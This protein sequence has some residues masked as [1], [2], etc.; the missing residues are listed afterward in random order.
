MNTIKVNCIYGDFMFETIVEIL[1]LV[2]ALSVDSFAAGLVYGV[3]KVKVPLLSVLIITFIS[4]MTLIIS[5]FIGNIISGMLPENFTDDVSFL[6]IYTIGV[7]KLLQKPKGDEADKA[8]KAN[9]DG[10]NILS[11]VEALYL[12]AALSIDSIAA[13]IGAGVMAVHAAWTLCVSLLVG[14][15]AIFFGTWLGRIISSRFRSDLQWVSGILMILLAFM[16]RV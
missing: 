3:G 6:I 4:S 10:D 9:K 8:D 11:P 16:R 15:L 5:I 12:G 1:V 13:G 14:G 2:T 7:V